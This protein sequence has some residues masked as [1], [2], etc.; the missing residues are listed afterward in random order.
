MMIY[1]C[2]YFQTCM[3]IEFFVFFVAPIYMVWYS[4]HGSMRTHGNFIEEHLIGTASKSF[5]L[6]KQHRGNWETSR[7]HWQWNLAIYVSVFAKLGLPSESQISQSLAKLTILVET[8]QF[9]QISCVQTLSK[10]AW[11]VWK[12]HSSLAGACCD[13]MRQNNIKLRTLR[14]TTLGNSL[15]AQ[16]RICPKVSISGCIFVYP[17][18]IFD[19]WL[20]NCK[21]CNLTSSVANLWGPNRTE[22]AW[23]SCPTSI[24]ACSSAAPELVC[25]CRSACQ[26]GW[27]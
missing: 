13:S 27:K 4:S 9:P 5:S 11:P 14:W 24:S 2:V 25:P 21:R 16:V 1:K 12:L 17:A 8:F 20:K 22:A 3:K 23:P 26:S 19:F 10:E 7:F 18:S 15:P 6:L